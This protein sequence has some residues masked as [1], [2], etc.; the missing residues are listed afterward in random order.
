MKNLVIIAHPNE[1]SFCYNGILRRSKNIE[2]SGQDLK[3]SICT[4]IVL[5]DPEC[6]Y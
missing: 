5:Q 6:D 2:R 3:L 4:E 1:D